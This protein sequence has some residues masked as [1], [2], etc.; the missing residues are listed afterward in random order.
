MADVATLSFQKRFRYLAEAASFFSFVA[1]FRAIGLDAASA[2]GGFIGRHIYSRMPPANTARENLKAAY[3]DKTATEIEAIVRHV[4]ENL[5]RVAGEY[6]HLG[7][8]TLG[9]G[10][11]IE[12]VGTEHAEA[13]IARGKG[14]IFVS[15]HFANW[16]VMPIAAALLK[17][18][19]AIVYRPP[20][21]PYIANWISKQRAK[22]GPAEQFAKGA[23]G[24]RRIFTHL[25]RGLSIFMLV[26]QKTYEGLPTPY[27]GRSALT[28]SAPA[29]LALKLGSVL[30]P[31]SCKRVNGAHFRVEINPPLEFTP[32]GDADGDIE[33]LTAKIT[34][35]L[36]AMVREDPTQWLWT[37]HRW[38]TSRDIEKMKARGLL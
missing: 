6:A 25:R 19:G 16:E 27:F 14:V 18:R 30:L 13:A 9:I 26:D 10:Q 17:Y 37:H 38:T 3:P 11:R 31:T 15:G 2:M 4:C 1:L 32:T 33:A 23:R 22:L 21:N 36:E 34:A 24:T 20:N 28:T 5:G 8:M 12:V 35:T 29:S 7:K